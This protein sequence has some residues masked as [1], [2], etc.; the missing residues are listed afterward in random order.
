MYVNL[1]LVLRFQI[2]WSCGT[3]LSTPLL[4]FVWAYHN[5]MWV[6]L[7]LSP[8]TPNQ[9]WN[10]DFEIRRKQPNMPVFTHFYCFLKNL[11]TREFAHIG[12][13]ARRLAS[14]KTT[15]T[16]KFCYDQ[17]ERK[18]VHIWTGVRGDNSK[19]HTFMDGNNNYIRFG[20]WAVISMLNWPIRL[21]KTECLK[22][23]NRGHWPTII[24]PI[25]SCR[26]EI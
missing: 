7:E 2:G 22:A 6:L 18:F 4:F 10:F 19:P 23:R 1:H 12:I 25:I 11:R 9:T 20:V 14:I 16:I 26:V 5:N 3:I 13:S 21:S 15:I 8:L 24:P 17:Y